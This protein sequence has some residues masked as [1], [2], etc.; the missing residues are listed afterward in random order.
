MTRLRM[1]RREVLASREVP[2][3]GTAYDF[4]IYLQSYNHNCAVITPAGLPRILAKTNACVFGEHRPTSRLDLQR[5]SIHVK[6][7]FYFNF[8]YLAHGGQKIVS[9]QNVK[10]AF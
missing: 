1:F 7:E 10:T 9:M 4:M 2:T 5:G 8:P 6:T 3:T